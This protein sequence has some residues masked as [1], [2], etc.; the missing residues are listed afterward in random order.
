MRIVREMEEA[1]EVEEVD[2]WNRI[3]AASDVV[4]NS[5]PGQEGTGR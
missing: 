3:N 5:P 2:E 1:D 4:L